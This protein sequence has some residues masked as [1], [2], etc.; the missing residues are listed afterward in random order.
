[1]NLA[2]YLEHSAKKHPDKV[3]IRH[4]GRQVTFRELDTNCNRFASGLGRWG[5]LRGNA[6]W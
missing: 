4:E 1:M 5:C 3:A 2:E 6:A